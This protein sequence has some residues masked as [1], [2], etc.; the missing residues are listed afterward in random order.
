MSISV[1]IQREFD[2]K[3]NAEKLAPLIMKL[4]TL[5]TSQQGYLTGQTFRSLD[6]EGEYLVISTWCSLGEWKRWRDS[7]ERMELQRQIDELLEEKT[8][9]RTYEPSYSGI[10]PKFDTVVY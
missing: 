2:E 3:V 5:A 6:R 1:I 9:Y 8:Q 7:E 4:R 10:V